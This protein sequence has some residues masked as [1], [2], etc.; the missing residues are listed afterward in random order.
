MHMSCELIPG[1]PCIQLALA[2][3]T[4]RCHTTSCPQ[5]QWDRQS[6]VL[7]TTRLKGLSGQDALSTQ[8]GLR[9]A[10]FPSHDST[11]SRTIRH[12]IL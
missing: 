11:L 4:P 3:D 8:L 1:V 2:S 12:S 10:L 9:T 7:Y 6:C 5:I